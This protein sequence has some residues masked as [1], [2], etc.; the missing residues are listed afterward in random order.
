MEK[1]DTFFCVRKKGE[2][3]NLLENTEIYGKGCTLFKYLNT[4]RYVTL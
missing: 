1:F 4:Q 3:K 2:Q